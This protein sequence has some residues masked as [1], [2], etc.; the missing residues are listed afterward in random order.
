MS[1]KKLKLMTFASVF[2]GTGLLCAG[3]AENHAQNWAQFSP[4][5]KPT[6][7]TEANLNLSAS[8]DVV[9]DQPTSSTLTLT[10]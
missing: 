10:Q 4:V 7:S 2:L 5:I 6:Q 1:L 3:C 9:M 8:S